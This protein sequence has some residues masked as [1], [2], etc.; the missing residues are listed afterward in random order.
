MQALFLTAEEAQEDEAVGNLP[1][2]PIPV[3]YPA[4]GSLAMLPLEGPEY[5][6]QASSPTLFLQPV[7]QWHSLRATGHAP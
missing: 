4:Y 1:E 5:K 6:A 2:L 7:S 3:T